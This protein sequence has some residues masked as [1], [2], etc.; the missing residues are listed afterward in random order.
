M[1]CPGARTRQKVE[2]AKDYRRARRG[3]P[4]HKLTAT[5]D[6]IGASELTAIFRH[7]LTR[8]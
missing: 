7:R 5:P 6:L 3:Q 2:Q 8:A 4:V 1:V